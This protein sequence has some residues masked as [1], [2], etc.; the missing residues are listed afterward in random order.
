MS[1]VF[2]INAFL[3]TFT[4]TNP[5]IGPSLLTIINLKPIMVTGV[6]N[7]IDISI[8]VTTI[9]NCP[10]ITSQTNVKTKIVN[11]ITFIVFAY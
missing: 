5:S 1:S 3:L 8:V 10:T 6:A 4:V 2:T 7:I 9:S 11:R